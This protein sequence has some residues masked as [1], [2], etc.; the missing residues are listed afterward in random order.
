MAARLGMKGRGSVGVVVGD[1]R[2]KII[3]ANRVKT[4]DARCVPYVGPLWYLKIFFQGQI[5]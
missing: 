2:Q 4:G 1:A 5:G 3:Q